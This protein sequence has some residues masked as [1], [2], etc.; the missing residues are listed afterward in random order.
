MVVLS[1]EIINVNEMNNAGA[2]PLHLAALKGKT[3]VAKLLIEANGIDLDLH[4]HGLKLA[5]PMHLAAFSGHTEILIL[6]A[7]AGANPALTDADGLYFSH[8]LFQSNCSKPNFCSK[9]HFR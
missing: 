8:K 7:D 1:Q 9:S 4:A 6:L 5:T 3:H 2:T